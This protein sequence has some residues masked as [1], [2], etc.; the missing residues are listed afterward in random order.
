MKALIL[1]L[2]LL[3]ACWPAGA[4]TF[5][6]RYDREIKAAAE[7]W[8]PG[9]PWRLWKAQLY[10]ESRLDP[11]ARSPAGAEGLAQFMPAT[12]KEITA[13]M[14]VA[15]VDRRAAGPSIEAGAYYMLR[16]R[17]NWSSQRPEADRHNLAMASYNA[18]LGHIL[19]AQ[20]A[21]GGPVLYEPI[22]ACLPQITGRHAAET[23][24]YAPRIRKWFALMEATR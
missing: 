7:R 6:T 12:W 17:R 4:Q 9:V 16:L 18:G 21:C 15:V 8:L 19:A 22:M 3:L 14:G 23:L 5:P 24:G 2:L 1:A 10:Q 13:A 11:N 20:R